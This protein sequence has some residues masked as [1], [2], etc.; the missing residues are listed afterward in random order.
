MKVKCPVC[1][2]LKKLHALGCMKIDCSNCNGTG[3][4]EEETEEEKEAAKVKKA[5]E[6]VGKPISAADDD[7][8]KVKRKKGMPKFELADE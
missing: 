3:F 2:G 7:E 8:I 6:L 5:K 1:N 4:V